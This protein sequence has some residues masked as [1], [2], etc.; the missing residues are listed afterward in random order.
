MEPH[1]RRLQPRLRKSLSS[2]TVPCHTQARVAPARRSLRAPFGRLPEPNRCLRR[3]ENPRLS[4]IPTGLLT[5]RV[6]RAA[7]S[8][9][10]LSRTQPPKKLY[11]TVNKVTPAVADDSRLRGD[12]ARNAIGPDVR[13]SR[14]YASPL[15]GSPA[16]KAASTPPRSS[17]PSPTAVPNAVRR[18][19]LLLRRTSLVLHR[20]TVRTRGETC[21]FQVSYVPHEN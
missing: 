21:Y 4:L 9:P 1:D 12:N 19:Q 16:S 14:T 3:H 15:E 13:F 20:H 17:S 18:R 5:A 7:P 8:L 6:H 11:H 10:A 2:L